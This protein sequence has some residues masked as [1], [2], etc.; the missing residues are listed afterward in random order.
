MTEPK[1]CLQG[2][3]E[4]ELPDVPADPN[5]PEHCAQHAASKGPGAAAIRSLLRRSIGR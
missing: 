2:G 4:V 3:C 1:R 5:W